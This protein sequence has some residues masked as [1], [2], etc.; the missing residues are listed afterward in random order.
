[1]AIV[2]RKSKGSGREEGG[3]NP[4]GHS[5]DSDRPLVINDFLTMQ[6]TFNGNF[7]STGIYF[8]EEVHSYSLDPYFI[9]LPFFDV[10]HYIT[11]H[12]DQSLYSAC[13]GKY[14]QSKIHFLEGSS[15]LVSKCVHPLTLL[16]CYQGIWGLL[17]TLG[18]QLHHIEGFR[19][20]LHDVI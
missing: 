15:Y 4:F 5:N 8:Q 11:G 16:Q 18:V 17:L 2:K 10:Q 6:A 14:L 20:L 3:S 7:A 13:A 1:M 9:R 12:Q 19:K